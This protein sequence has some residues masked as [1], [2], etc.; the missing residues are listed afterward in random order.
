M[1]G[2]GL[3]EIGSLKLGQHT[4]EKSFIWRWF[5]HN[6]NVIKLERRE[7]AEEGGL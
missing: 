7:W 2:V 3:W 4:M 5:L 6:S 1:H